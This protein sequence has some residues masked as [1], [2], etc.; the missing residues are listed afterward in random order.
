MQNEDARYIELLSFWAS[1]VSLNVVVEALAVRFN[2]GHNSV[3]GA[4]MGKFSIIN[5]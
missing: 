3:E 5:V 1:F 4:G 2:Y